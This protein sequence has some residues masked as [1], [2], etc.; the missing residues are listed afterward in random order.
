MHTWIKAS[1]V[2]VLLGM[3]IVA[4]S[5]TGQAQQPQ[6]PQQ[7]MRFFITSVGSAM[8]AI[9]VVWRE[10]TNTARHWPRLQGLATV[11]GVRI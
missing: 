6:A 9:S 3:L 10:P 2:V 7:P 11:R 8:A 5:S 1:V 4:G